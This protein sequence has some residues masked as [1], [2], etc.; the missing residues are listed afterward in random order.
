MGHSSSVRYTSLFLGMGH[1]SSV[2]YLFVFG[3]GSQP[4]CTVHRFVFGNGSQPKC[5]LSLCLWERVTAQV[6]GTSLCL[7]EWVTAQVYV[8]SLCLWEWE[9]LSHLFV[10]GKG[11]H[12]PRHGQ[13]GTVTDEQADGLMNR[14]TNPMKWTAPRLKL[15]HS[16]SLVMGHTD[17]CE[18]DRQTQ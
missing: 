2:R 18:E 10:F 6:Y 12:G 5:T 11:S 17:F 3:N 7:W 15:Y 13:R 9:C 14:E 1:S 4:K 8:T 16:V